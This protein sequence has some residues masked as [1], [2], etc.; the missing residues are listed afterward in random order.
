MLH[1][2]LPCC[3]AQ[4]VPAAL[5]AQPPCM[6]PA[7]ACPA[8][9]R[10]PPSGPLTPSASPQLHIEVDGDPVGDSPYP[11]FF[12]AAKLVVEGSGAAAAGAAAAPGQPA[13]AVQP[14]SG[15]QLPAPVT[16]SAG[17]QVGSRVW[18]CWCSCRQSWAAGSTLQPGGRQHPKL[19]RRMCQLHCASA[20]PC[21]WPAACRRPSLPLTS[22]PAPATRRRWSLPRASRRPR[23]RRRRSWVLRQRRV[24]WAQ[25]WR[26]RQALQR[27]PLCRTLW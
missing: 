23:R 24:T 12:S 15:A 26:W 21:G 6:A 20:L 5:H 8:L 22:S 18:L 25:A 3:H 11:V 27:A 4:C 1:A 13:Q 17:F 2:A 14:A 7:S 9:P 16:T 10:T 19:H